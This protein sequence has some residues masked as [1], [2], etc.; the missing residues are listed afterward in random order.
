MLVKS[1]PFTGSSRI[2]SSGD[3]IKA[4]ASKAWEGIK[5]AITG[6]IEAAKNTISG[7]IERIKGFFPLSL[8][9]TGLY[10]YTAFRMLSKNRVKRAAENTKYLSAFYQTKQKSHQTVLR[11]KNRKE[12]KY[13]RCPQCKALLRMK[14]GSGTMHVTCGKCRHQ[15]D[16]KA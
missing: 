5:N 16:K 12:Y 11:L 7:I 6:P 14:R 10:I 2:I 15:F 8:A 13:F 4:A 1:R 3:D 9:S